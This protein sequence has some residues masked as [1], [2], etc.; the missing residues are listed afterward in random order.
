[1]GLR[2]FALSSIFSIIVMFDAAGVRRHAGEHAALLN[3]L[4]DEFNQL[5]RK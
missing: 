1:M 2:F 3:K 5:F 4:V